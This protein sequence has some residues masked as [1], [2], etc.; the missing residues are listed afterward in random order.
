MSLLQDKQIRVYV[1]FLALFAF[2]TFCGG[3]LFAADQNDAVRSSCIIH[4][5]TIA[6]SLLKQGVSRDVI[7]NALTN[8]EISQGGMEL[9]AALGMEGQT[10]P[11]SLPYLSQFQRDTLITVWIGLTVLLTV[12]FAGTL[13]FFLKRKK[14]YQQAGK[15]IESYIN[16]DFSLHLPQ[17]SEGAIFSVFASVEQLATMLQAKSDTE[18][19]AKEFLKSTISDISHQL[20]TPLAAITIYQEIIADEPENP[21]TVKV[22]SGKIGVSLKRMEELIQSMLKITRLDT[23]N[24]VFEK[25]NCLVTELI[26]RSISELTDRAITENKQIIL[27]GNSEQ[28]VSCDPE[29]TGEAI[30]NIVKNALDHTKPGDTIQISWERTPVILRIVITD[31]GSGIAPEDIH[32]IFKRFYRSKHSLETPGIGLGLPLAKSIITGQNGLLSVQSELNKGT[33]FTISF[34]TES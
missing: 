11:D 34:L 1:L 27:K 22:F 7:A 14:L 29:W 13:I 4:D 16:G 24:I 32:H 5:K 33:S 15:A 28:E 17:N 19:K 26:L 30:G 21:E 20:K 31:S 3:G 2:V 6:S 12:L 23:G 8:T 10:A 18:H 25:R 9:L